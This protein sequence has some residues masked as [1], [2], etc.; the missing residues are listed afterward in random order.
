LS[1]TFAR[2][3]VG[4]NVD[5][6]QLPAGNSLLDQLQVIDLAVL[7]TYLALTVGCGCWF[8]IRR[9]SSDEFMAGGRAIPGWAAGLSMFGS[10]VSSISFLANPGKAFAADWNSF[11]FNLATPIAAIAACWWFVPFYRRSGEISAYEHL[12]RRFGPWARTYAVACFLLTQV[13]RT[14]TILYLLALATAPLT[15]WSVETIILLTGALMIVYTVFGGIEAVVWIGV[16]QSIVLILGPLVCLVTLLDLI[17]G[18]PAQLVADA[19]A[20]GKFSLGSFSP[21]LTQSTFWVVLLYGLAMNLGNF[22]VDQSYVQR[23]VSTASDREAKRSVMLTA[24]LYV[25]VSA[26]FFLIGT[27]LYVLYHSRPE[28]FPTTLDAAREPDKVFPY[29]IAH[30]L[31]LGM[32]GLVVAAIFAASIDSNLSSMATLTLCDI[33]KRYLRPQ[34]GERESLRVLRG[35]TLFWGILGIFAALAMTRVGSTL[36]VWWQLAGIFS[37]GMLG[38]FLLGLISRRAQRFTAL[39]AVVAGILSIIWMSLSNTSLWPISLAC[40]RNPLHE[41]MTTV[42]GTLA[43]LLVGLCLSWLGPKRD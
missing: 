32:A 25:P 1:R 3:T 7:V 21:S 37:G 29:F 24:G 4:R 41:L 12:E 15:G 9:R 16:L 17:P 11:V 13:A 33:Y 39:A 26:L 18:G 40:F 8:A 14:G 36:D 19:S 28:L 20:A 35:A 27:G 34:A 31:P 38:L 30:R 10:Y 23:Y 6:A 22:S 2:V 42:V 5:S 43:I